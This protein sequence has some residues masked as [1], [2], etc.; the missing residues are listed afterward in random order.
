MINFYS[1]YAEYIAPELKGYSSIVWV[2][3]SGDNYQKQ[4]PDEHLHIPLG[5]HHIVQPVGLRP[6]GLDDCRGLED[7][8]S[9]EGRILA[10]HRVI[11]QTVEQPY[12][13]LG[14]LQSQYSTL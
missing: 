14:F 13:G 12:G 6:H 9:C 7:F 5:Q 3:V 10:V 8:P 11:V 1:L 2:G 4:V